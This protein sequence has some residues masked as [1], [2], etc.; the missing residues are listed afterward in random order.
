[1]SIVAKIPNPIDDLDSKKSLIKKMYAKGST[2]DELELFIMACKKTGLDPFMKQIYAI[3][4]SDQ[5]TI[6]TSIDGL[7]LI[8]DRT[9]NYA[10]G[11]EA[12]C[13]YD[14]QK[15][16]L[17]ATSFVKKRTA[18]GTWHEVSASAYFDEYCQKTKDGYP[19]K[20]WKQMPHV[21]LAKC[22]EALALRKA[23]P[24]ELSGIYTSDEMSQA[25]TE[26]D[27][28]LSMPLTD[29]QVAKMDTLMKEVNDDA[30]LMQLTE[31]MEKHM[32]VSSVWD[33]DQRSY[34][35]VMNSLEKKI[36]SKKEIMNGSESVA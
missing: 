28:V 32:K 3:K 11:R 8:A 7:R 18:D 1:M 16:L 2:D 10:P 35:K 20:F 4:R 17:C 19:T 36:S 31:Y 23:F 13:D 34:A 24:A 27:D 22:A 5:M 30:Y 12:R 15:K 21:M 25:T 33:L 29:E 14:D 6:Q 26:E 9:K